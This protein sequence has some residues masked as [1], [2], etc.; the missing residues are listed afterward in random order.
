MTHDDNPR[1]HYMKDDEVNY[2]EEFDDEDP[3]EL[4]AVLD[5]DGNI[6]QETISD[7]D[8]ADSDCMDDT[9][10]YTPE[11][12]DSVV[13]FHGHQDVFACALSPDG[14]Y[15]G[16]GGQ[17]ECFLLWNTHSGIM[18]F[19]SA[20]FKD[21]VT[22]IEFSKDGKYIAAGDMAGI[23]VVWKIVGGNVNEVYSLTVDDGLKWLQWHPQSNI[24]LVGSPTIWMIQ[25][26]T[27]QVKVF[28]GVEPS[29]DIGRFMPDGKR[30]AIGYD[31]GSTKILD[32]ASGTISCK[33]PSTSTNLDS[34]ISMAVHPDNDIIAVGSVSS[35]VAIFKTQRPKL[36]GTLDCIETGVVEGVQEML[37]TSVES[38][39]FGSSAS[40][41][42]KLLVAGTDNAL[43]IV[44]YLKLNVRNTIKV[45]E[46]LTR[47]VWPEGS[48][49]IFVGTKKGPINVYNPFTNEQMMSFLGH[50]S[51]IFDINYSKMG[52]KL[53]TGGE[54]VY[55]RIF[56]MVE[57]RPLESAS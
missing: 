51:T 8:E 30:A 12:D 4:V 34:I 6:I 5:S 50:S 21:S 48:D 1:N 19:K 47:F 26:P 36:L 22:M 17:D 39:Q 10:F 31:D 37:S 20:C 40:S 28:P 56:N 38:L 32:L 49:Y 35:K 43:H 57:V 2:L 9:D 15:A 33:F 54:D 45:A 25:I 24:L 46:G 44:D 27:C 42:L 11:R 53:I 16:T 23:V 7:G 3:G 18:L 41:P 55:V 52:K 13:K 14:V 29:T